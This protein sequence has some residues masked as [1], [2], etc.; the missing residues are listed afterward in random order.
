MVDF[1]TLDLL[2][3]PPE[4]PFRAPIYCVASVAGYITSSAGHD[5]LGIN[6]KPTAATS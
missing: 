5:S 6:R 3:A 2:K 4:D 1:Y